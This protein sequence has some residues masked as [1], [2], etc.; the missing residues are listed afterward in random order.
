M[1]RIILSWTILFVSVLFCNAHFLNLGKRNNSVDCTEYSI[2]GACRV[3][4]KQSDKDQENL[5]NSSYGITAN[6]KSFGIYF[7][8]GS[9]KVKCIMSI[10]KTK[11]EFSP[12]GGV[13][14]FSDQNN[15][16]IFVCNEAMEPSL[17][18]TCGDEVYGMNI[19][20]R[21][22]INK[23]NTIIDDILTNSQFVEWFKSLYNLVRMSQ[24]PMESK[25]VSPN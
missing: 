8:Y 5:Q 1:K 22:V 19:A 4:S 12:E 2:V 21:F 9:K 6:E 16:I 13:Y 7:D 3:K 23:S 15:S 20:G 10:N 17:L 25:L 24:M 14:S 11:A 18:V